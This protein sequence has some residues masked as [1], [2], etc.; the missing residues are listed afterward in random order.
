MKKSQALTEIIPKK[1]GAKEAENVFT[2]TLSILQ[3]NG[4]YSMMLYLMAQIGGGR[5]KDKPCCIDT[6]YHALRL[7]LQS[8]GEKINWTEKLDLSKPESRRELLKSVLEN[9]CQDSNK[10]I[11]ARTVLERFLIYARFNAKALSEEGKS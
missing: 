8:F 7:V 6:A 2:K 10:T 9:V 1:I 5:E 3:E 11:L 4:V